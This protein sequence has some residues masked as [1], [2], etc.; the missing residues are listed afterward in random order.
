MAGLIA[1]YY[2]LEWFKFFLRSIPPARP[3]LLIQDGHTSHISIELIELARAN[4][5][6][7]LCLPSHTTHLLQPLDVGVF[8]SF[9][10]HFSKACVSYHS[11]HPGR[12]ITNDMIAS[13]VSTAYPNAFTP[14]GVGSTQ[15]TSVKTF[16]GSDVLSEMLVLP[17]QP[18]ERLRKRGRVLM[19]EVSVSRMTMCFNS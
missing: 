8:K 1:T 14:T 10:T 4:D 7:I 12:V 16:S 11:K 19:L 17:Q 3:V 18:K 5:V 9:K 6:C 15:S 13:L 2:Y